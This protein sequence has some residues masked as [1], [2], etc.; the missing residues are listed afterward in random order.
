MNSKTILVH[1]H[2]RRPRRHVSREVYREADRAEVLRLFNDFVADARKEFRKYDRLG[3]KGRV[4]K[5]DCESVCFVG[6]SFSL[7]IDFTERVR[8]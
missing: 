6:E 5:R 7:T 3:I 1:P 8:L 4:N 2:I